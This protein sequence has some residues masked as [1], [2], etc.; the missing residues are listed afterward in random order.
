MTT[1]ATSRVTSSLS[2][3]LKKKIFS[4][5]EY[6]TQQ[7]SIVRALVCSLVYHSLQ[8]FQRFSFLKL[9][10]F[11]R[12]FFHLDFLWNPN[13]PN[14]CHSRLH[15]LLVLFHDLLIISGIQLDEIA[16]RRIFQGKKRAL[17]GP[18]SNLF[19][20]SLVSLGLSFYHVPSLLSYFSEL[21]QEPPHLIMM[22]E[23]Q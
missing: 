16:W 10:R 13:S 12:N 22:I 2:R 14:Q 3:V 5:K 21:S 8:S 15:H 6:N 4:P 11:C 20:V 18:F 1:K 7:K 9:P 23:L 17:G 19:E